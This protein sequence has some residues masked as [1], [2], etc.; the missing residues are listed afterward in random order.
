MYETVTIEAD[1]RGVATLWLD[2]AE[3]HNALSA[4]LISDLHAVC[5]IPPREQMQE[6]ISKARQKGRVSISLASELRAGD[7]IMATFDCRYA[8]ILARE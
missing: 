2:R 8:V 7:D 3:K 5:E 6:S 4:Q 1:A